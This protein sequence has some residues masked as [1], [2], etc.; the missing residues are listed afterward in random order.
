M[1]FQIFSFRSF[2][3]LLV[4]K[5]TETQNTISK[6]VDAFLSYIFI[7]NFRRNKIAFGVC[8]HIEGQILYL[9]ESHA[10]AILSR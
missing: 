3:L 2:V 7:G 6:S 5:C 9:W 4:M 1:P 10:F 8:S